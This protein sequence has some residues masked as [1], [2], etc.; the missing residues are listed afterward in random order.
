[1]MSQLQRVFAG[2]AG[3]NANGLL[4]VAD[5]HLAIADLAGASRR[6]DG[7][8]DG[9]GA[10]IG[11]RDIDLDLRDEID[12]ILGSPIDLGVSLLTTE[13]SDF[14]GGQPVYALRN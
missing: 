2:L 8:D 6:L 9:L 12:R 14:G 5:E 7:V 1:M 10:I 11:D 4:D 3:A 13:A